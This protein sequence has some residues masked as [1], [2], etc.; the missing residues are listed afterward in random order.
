MAP[1]SE[2]GRAYDLVEGLHLRQWAMRAVLPLAALATNGAGRL[3]VAW[4]PRRADLGLPPTVETGLALFGG[5]LVVAAAALRVLAKGVLVRKETL[6]RGGVYARVRHPF[7]L[8]NLV[9][10]L[11]TFL[12]AGSLG[13]MVG[14]AWIAAAAPLYLVTIRAEDSALARLFPAESAAY[15]ARVRALLPGRRA[16]DA[17]AARPTW[18]NLVAEREPPRLLRFLAGALLVLGLTLP[19]AP[20]DVVLVAGA[21]IFA[22]SYLLR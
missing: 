10:A 4:L 6:T 19:G 12:L 18:S 8:A 1:R 7:Y 22:A 5:A 15:A 2:H 16:P 14:T 3:D 21:L 13:A 20:G 17:P 9:G 11:G